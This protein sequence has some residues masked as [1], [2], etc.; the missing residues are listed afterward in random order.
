MI[1]HDMYVQSVIKLYYTCFCVQFSV[2][3]DVIGNM[4]RPSPETKKKKRKRQKVRWQLKFSSKS[5]SAHDSS[6]MLLAALSQMR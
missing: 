4:E 6:S 5:D 2:R 3:I 1:G